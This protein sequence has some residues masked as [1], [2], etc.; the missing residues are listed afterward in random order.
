MKRSEVEALINIM[1]VIA[2]H[3]AGAAVHQRRAGS[4]DD[5]IE[6]EMWQFEFEEE[7]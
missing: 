1:K 3:A 6:E 5:A 4:L 2:W 7:E